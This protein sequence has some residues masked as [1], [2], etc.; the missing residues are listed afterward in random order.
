MPFL[1]PFSA[2]GGSAAGGKKKEE[3]TPQQKEAKAAPAQKDPSGIILN[4]YLSEKASM[5]QQ[6]NQ[7][8]FEVFS[9]ATKPMIRNAVSKMYGVNAQKVRIIHVGPAKVRVGRFQGTKPGFKK[10]IVKLAKGQKIDSLSV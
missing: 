5:L 2:R 3:Q 8:V 4:P 6:D 9:G 1:N 10:A 7:Y